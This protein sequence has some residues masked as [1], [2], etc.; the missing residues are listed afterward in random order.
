[1][2]ILDARDVLP[3]ETVMNCTTC[4]RFD[5]QIGHPEYHFGKTYEKLQEE[6]AKHQY[7]NHSFDARGIKSM[8]E[9]RDF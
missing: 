5:L 8:N 4:I 6:L 2:S 3:I 9:V 7:E 1:M